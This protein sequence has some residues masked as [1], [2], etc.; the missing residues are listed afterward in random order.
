M[1]ILRLAKLNRRVYLH[2]VRSIES[3]VDVTNVNVY[4]IVHAKYRVVAR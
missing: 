3:G 2:F 1:L 4:G